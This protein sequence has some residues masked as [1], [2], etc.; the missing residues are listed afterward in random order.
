MACQSWLVLLGVQAIFSGCSASENLSQLSLREIRSY[1]LTEAR[2]VKGAAGNLSTGLLIWGCTSDPLY[3][4]K[5]GAITSIRAQ[6]SIIAGAHWA[7][8]SS[9]IDIVSD[10]GWLTAYDF[11]G[12]Q[13]A[14][15][16]RMT[17][18]PVLAAAAGPHA[19]YLLCRPTPDSLLILKL[20]RHGRLIKQRAM[21]EA[22]DSGT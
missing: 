10:S 15:T 7:P 9:N 12:E 6:T 14:A 21:S 4:L 1:P 2:F 18:H 22:S 17:L 8:T 3:V 13:L 20:D 11:T 16:S 19:W 5:G